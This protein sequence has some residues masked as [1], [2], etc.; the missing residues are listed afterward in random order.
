M[1]ALAFLLKCIPKRFHHLLELCTTLDEVLDKLSCWTLDSKI[2]T[3]RV[4]VQ[5]RGLKK[6]TTL[7]DD[8]TLAIKQIA[9]FERIIKIDPTY[10]A[11]IP[12]LSAH[13]A[14]FSSD[15]YYEKIMTRLRQSAVQAGDDRGQSNYTLTFI[16]ILEDIV[17]DINFKISSNDM[18]SLGNNYTAQTNTLTTSQSQNS[19]PFTPRGRGRGRGR[20]GNRNND[21]AGRNNDGAGASNDGNGG[22]VPKGP[23]PKPQCMICQGPHDNLFR[24]PKFL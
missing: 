15:T 14:K 24:C 11:S 21:G 1:Q 22:A 8:K 12:A 17:C 2:H 19:Q 7:R 18:N 4:E 20:G 10:W 9:L 3:E 16:G 23:K 5:L 6:S 13:A